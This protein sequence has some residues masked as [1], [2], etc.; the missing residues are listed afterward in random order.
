MCPAPQSPIGDVLDEEPA[1]ASTASTGR[2]A[3]VIDAHASLLLDANREGWALWG[4]DPARAEP[5]IAIDCAMPA[6]QRL[7]EMTCTQR[8]SA[9]EPISLAFWTARGLVQ[10]ACRVEPRETPGGSSAMLV[11]AAHA[12]P[13]PAGRPEAGLATGQSS[14]AVSGLARRGHGVDLDVALD[15]WL[16]H[17][18]RTPLS[19]VI[20]YAEI[21]KSEHFGPI[22]NPR[23]K[24]Y[25]CDIY[26]SARHALGVVDSM[27]QGDRARTALPTLS[28]AD[29]DPAAV[30]EGC[31]TVARP[32]AERAGLELAADVPAHLP[33]IVADEL[34]L[35]QMLLNLLSNAIKFA[36]AGDRV[37]VRVVYTCD[38]PLTIS[39]TD[40]GPG[41]A[42]EPPKAERAGLGLGLPLTRALAAANGAKL[43]VESTPGQG[44]RVT[45]SFGKDR[46]VPV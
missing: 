17:E 1:R 8:R 22:A 44:T 14:S 37:A 6:L 29:L 18:L 7:R 10:L 25:A 3:L 27:L 24:S 39:V 36:R 5:P 9:D 41:M 4:L 2:P 35:R 15:A 19:A 11:T 34:A 33:R 31:L 21:L 45:I 20:A 13:T 32:L 40:T 30:V 38:G 26:D 12:V 42:G 43:A 16:A 46:I 28:F 23:Y